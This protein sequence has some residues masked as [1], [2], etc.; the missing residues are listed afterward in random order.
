M[1]NKPGTDQ[2]VHRI[3]ETALDDTPWRDLFPDLVARFSACGGQLF[4]PFLREGPQG[5]FEL[6]HG[7]NPAKTQHRL[8][9]VADRDLWYHEL[10]RHFGV[11]GRLPT[12]LIYNAS[13]RLP[14]AE[15]RRTRSFAEYV[16]R[17][18]IG[19]A[20]GTAIGDGSKE[21]QPTAA[22]IFYRN[23]SAKPFETADMA[24]LR[25]LQ[26][27]FT[28]ALELRMRVRRAATDAVAQTF[29]I[30][31]DAVLVLA[32]DGTVL[33]TNPAAD[34]LLTQHQYP[35]VRFG[36]LRAQL[37]RQG[38]DLDR[39]LAGCTSGGMGAPETFVVRLAGQAGSGVIAHLVPPP[40]RWPVGPKAAAIAFLLVEGRGA[41]CPGHLLKTLYGLSPSE[42][43]LVMA[44]SEGI[45]PEAHAD[46]R[47]VSMNTV[48]TQLKAVFD[49]TQVRR[50][51]DLIRLVYSIT[52]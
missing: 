31:T 25:R 44:L 21:T 6:A 32:A 36:R 39:A 47:R 26:R 7:P 33:L 20:L 42:A 43:A 23:P 5:G 4:T 3:Y 49:K 9:E 17:L 52:R 29:D 1:V 48:R 46:A 34:R 14:K 10:V 30:V 35:Q 16:R 24:R 18:D 12:G 51:A 19:E 8:T 27:H 22:L 2:L 38:A 50:Q 13:E 11:D 37:A 40:P 15:L 45:T 28:R 41:P